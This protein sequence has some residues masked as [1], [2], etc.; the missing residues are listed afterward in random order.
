MPSCSSLGLNQVMCPPSDC[1]EV[2]TGT[3]SFS[4]LLINGE[5]VD[6]RRQP[7]YSSMCLASSTFGSVQCSIEGSLS[8]PF[9]SKA[10]DD[11]IRKRGMGYLCEQECE[12]PSK[13]TCTLGDSGWRRAG[14]Q[15]PY[16]I[17]DMFQRKRNRIEKKTDCKG[18]E[19]CQASDEPCPRSHTGSHQR[20]VEAFS[21]GSGDPFGFSP[22][23]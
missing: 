14:E 18:L 21:L 20:E 1:L 6:D 10:P 23:G 7:S 5:H 17:G 4:C 8:F 2:G 3:P 13:C 11:M 19:L 9:S 22:R 12:H 16:I 15:H